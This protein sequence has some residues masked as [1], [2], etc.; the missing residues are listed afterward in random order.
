[1]VS[2][3]PYSNTTHCILTLEASRSQF[4]QFSKTF[5]EHFQKGY[6]Q[7]DEKLLIQLCHYY[8]ELI[9]FEGKSYTEQILLTV[10]KKKGILFTLPENLKVGKK[11]RC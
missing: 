2:F 1:M 10:L 9:K 7:I 6:N 4:K 3:L 11:V 5:S 8:F